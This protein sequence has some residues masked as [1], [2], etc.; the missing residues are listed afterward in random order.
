MVT[1][2]DI[3]WTIRKRQQQA[4][5]NRQTKSTKSNKQQFLKDD[6]YC[7]QLVMLVHGEIEFNGKQNSRVVKQ[8]ELTHI[9]C[10][11]V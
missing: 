11:D 4:K 7:L 6:Y 8:K 2:L 1:Q 5:I 10:L 9:K 3:L